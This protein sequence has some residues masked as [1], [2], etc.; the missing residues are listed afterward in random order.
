M[1]SPPDLEAMSF[2]AAPAPA[3]MME[4]LTAQVGAEGTSVTF[5][6]VQK[7]SVPSDG[8]PHKV[9]VTTFDLSPQ[10]DYLSVPKLAEAVYRR[11]KIVNRS[12]FLLLDGPA[13][14]F[15]A[16]GFVGTLPLKRTAP[17]EEFELSLGVDDRVTVKRE[18]KAREADKKL[19]GDRRRLR[20][21][22]AIEI[23]NLRAQKIELELRDQFPVSRHEQVK[24]KLEACDP[25]PIEQTDLNELKWRLA[26]EPG[27]KTIARF[28]FSIEQPTILQVQGLP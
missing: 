10:I 6:L 4:A 22:Y 5:Q 3:M 17:N 12:E 20:V 14:L 2:G 8:S 16:G 1:E 26:L 7:V 25:K 11:A 21:V 15:I 28:E 23:K 9:T 27:A 24:V 18:L 13:S 19:I